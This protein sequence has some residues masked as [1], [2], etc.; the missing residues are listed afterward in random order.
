MS[1]EHNHAFYFREHHSYVKC[2]NMLIKAGT[3][4]NLQ[5]ANGMTALISVAKWGYVKCMKSLLDAGADVNKRGSSTGYTVLILASRFGHCKCVDMILEAGADVNAIDYQ[6]STALNVPNDDDVTEKSIV[7]I[8]K[9][10]L[11]TGIHINKF[12]S[13]GYNALM[14]ILG[15]TKRGA[16]LILY[17]AGETIE[18]LEG[19]GVDELPEELK[20]EDEKLQLKHICREAIRKHLLKLDPHQHLFSRIPRLELPSVVTEYLLFNVSLE[21][22]DADDDNSEEDDNDDD[23]DDQEEEEDDDGDDD[24]D[25]EEEEEDDEEEEEDEEDDDGDDDD[26]DD[27][28]KA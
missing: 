23:S 3:D 8:T 13:S 27:E 2:V 22:R 4:V 14:T 1:L 9:R 12:R 7:Y 5:T 21:T 11:R 28:T 26:N 16:A 10:L 25:D 20:F 6:G 24:N 19:T 17:A 15:S 18:T